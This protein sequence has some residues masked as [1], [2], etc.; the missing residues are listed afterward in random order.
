MNHME[1]ISRF[2]QLRKLPAATLVGVIG[3]TGLS[4]CTGEAATPTGYATNVEWVCLG[5]GAT[6]R[7]KPYKDNNE[8]NA[9]AVLDLNGKTGDHSEDANEWVCYSPT[10]GVVGKSAGPE[11]NAN[12]TYFQIDPTAMTAGD[13]RDGYGNPATELAV[14]SAEDFAKSIDA[15]TG[16][17]NTQRVKLVLK[18]EKGEGNSAF[19][20][21]Q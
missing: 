16:W 3:A 4:A 9:V 11:V 7:T 19:P 17:T 12:G 18:D 2:N 8:P 15:N 20:L 21:E 5:D 10:D 6:A 13:I 1:P 14:V